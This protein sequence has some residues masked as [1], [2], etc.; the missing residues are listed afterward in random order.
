MHHEIDKPHECNRTFLHGSERMNTIIRAGACEWVLTCLG[1]E[2]QCN[3]FLHSHPLF[4]R[5]KLEHVS[6]RIGDGELWRRF[7]DKRMRRHGN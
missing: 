4:F 7:I 5:G 2:E 3:R 1:V 6:I